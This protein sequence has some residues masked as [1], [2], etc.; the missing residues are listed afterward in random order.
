MKDNNI[1]S[2]LKI[3]K[4]AIFYGFLVDVGGTFLSGAIIGLILGFVLRDRGIELELIIKNPFVLTLFF[5]I[6]AG[7]SVIGGLVAALKGK[8]SYMKHAWYLGIITLALGIFVLAIEY[9][10]GI[11]ASSLDKSA[12]EIALDILALLLTLPLVLLGGHLAGKMKKG[13]NT[14]V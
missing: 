7:F 12:Y 4:K 2:S 9:A 11:V 5:L 1:D 6:G 13:E 8:H 14:N 3:S 10:N